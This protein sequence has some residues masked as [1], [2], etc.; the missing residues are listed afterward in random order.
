MPEKS[1]EEIINEVGLDSSN[2][3]SE[4]D[5]LAELS[6]K[7]EEE[8]LLEL[9]DSNTEEENISDETK[10]IIENEDKD[11]EIEL[12]NSS[13]TIEKKEMPIQKKQPKVYRILM[14]VVALLSIILVIGLILYFTG[15]FEPEPIKPKKTA[16][17]KV[18]K[19][20]VFNEKEINKDKLNKKLTM[21]TKK[22]IMDKN[23]LKEKELKKKK[24]EEEKLARIEEEKRL[25]KIE[26][27]KQALIEEQNKLKKEQEAL[28]TIQEK[29]KEEFEEQKKQLLLD[30]ENK[31][32]QNNTMTLIEPIPE[33]EPEIE[34]QNTMEE[35]STMQFLSFINVATI[36]GNLYKSYLDK[37]STIDKNISLCR[38]YKNRIEI[39]FGPYDSIKEREK[40]FNNLIKNDFKEAYLVDFTKEE[41]DKRCNY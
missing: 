15:F 17:K 28:L 21:L 22:E 24:E 26:E 25:A 39:Y 19:E 32:M 6:I 33:P 14:A 38:D 1:D 18:E 13:E 31:K 35:A 29:L 4:D 2:D 27:E 37:A 41:Y 23:E 40:V 34:S 30:L 12:K 16:I 10:K 7:G 3:I 20:I 36:K 11:D 9:V 5:A 8:G